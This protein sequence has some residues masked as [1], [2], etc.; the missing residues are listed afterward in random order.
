MSNLDKIDADLS[1]PDSTLED[2]VK[3]VSAADIDKVLASDIPME[4]KR[5]Q[6]SGL[7]TLLED[8]D[9]EELLAQAKTALSQVE[10]HIDDPIIPQITS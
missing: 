8:T 10:D 6:L 7:I 2:V 4:S 3:T 1:A 5:S 9:R